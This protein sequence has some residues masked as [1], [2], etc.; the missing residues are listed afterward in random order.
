MRVVKTSPA[1]ARAMTRAAR[2][3][4]IPARRSPLTSHSPVCTPARMGDPVRGHAPSTA[5]SI[6]PRGLARR[7]RQEYRQRC[8]PRVVLENRATSSPAA[9]S[10]ASSNVSQGASPNSRARRGGIDEV[11][12]QNRGENAVTGSDLAGDLTCDELLHG[13]HHQ[14]APRQR[15]LAPPITLSGNDLNSALDG[16]LNTVEGFVPCPANDRGV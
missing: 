10:C 11:S 3:R 5:G 4:V 8:A 9:A 6:A 7:R 15:W 2:C 12:E 14:E 16:E 13:V 1:P